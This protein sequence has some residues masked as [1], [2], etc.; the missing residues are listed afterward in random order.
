MFFPHIHIYPGEKRVWHLARIFPRYNYYHFTSFTDGCINANVK[1]IY[2]LN[3]FFFP[4]ICFLD[5]F[6][7]MA[8]WLEAR[9]LTK[10]EIRFGLVLFSSLNRSGPEILT[11][12]WGW[13]Y[14]PEA[15]PAQISTRSFLFSV[16]LFSLLL[17][18]VT[19][20]LL[21]VRNWL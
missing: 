7:V 5:D 6:A 12:F 19:C 3:R 17:S 10:T 11:K 13:L 15:G 4:P 18:D 14:G 16:S 8:L 9:N 1:E 2:H 21:D 20:V